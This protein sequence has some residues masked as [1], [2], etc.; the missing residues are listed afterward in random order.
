M[1]A[2]LSGAGGASC[3]LCTANHTQLKDL[4]LIEDGFSINHFIQDAKNLFKDVSNH[5][6]FLKLDS[7]SKYG[8]THPPISEKDILPYSTSFK[9]E[10]QILLKK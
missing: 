6:E 9:M 10:F 7:K 1:S 3:Q 8:L 4:N 5:E 2:T